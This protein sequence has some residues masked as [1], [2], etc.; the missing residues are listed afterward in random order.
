MTEPRTILIV[1]PDPAELASFT[2]LL[3]MMWDLHVAV[4]GAEALQ[5]AKAIVPDAIILDVNLPD[6]DG[7][8]LAMELAANESTSRVPLLFLSQRDDLNT[9]LRAYEAGGVDFVHK[10]I[11]PEALAAKIQVVLDTQRRERDLESA[12]SSAESMAF[13]IMTNLGETGTVMTC[14]RSLHDCVDVQGLAR[15][16]LNTL[17]EW[18]LEAT[19]RINQQA[20]IN[21]FNA[22]G[23]A[24][25]LEISI[26]DKAAL[27]GRIFSLRSHMVIN[28]PFLSI[29]VR[30]MPVDDE[31]RCGR[32]R[33]Y[34]A[35]IAEA[36]SGRAEVLHDGQVWREQTTTLANVVRGTQGAVALVEATYR[37]RRAATVA[38]LQAMQQSLGSGYAHIGLTDEQEE[39][40]T[41]IVRDAVDRT[42]DVFDE[43]LGL[44]L[45]L[46][47]ALAQLQSLVVSK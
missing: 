42:L 26:M 44:D 18:Q 32:L 25:P 22:N 28:Y 1:D 37:Q 36:S 3:G 11:E 38:V 30:N 13:S 9:C 2:N 17:H 34:V 33:D 35:I 24:S 10:A 21:T 29:L 19:V 16:C 23:P 15:H 6:E 7:F 41:S 47:P 31:D 5:K 43:G 8:E 12:K 27:S 4:S 39:A 14:L 46:T 45:S 40:L 20:G